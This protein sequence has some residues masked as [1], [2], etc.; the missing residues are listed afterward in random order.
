MPAI[1]AILLVAFY[2]LRTFGPYLLIYYVVAGIAL[3]WQW[4]SLAVPS[5]KTWLTGKG[6][7]QEEVDD[8]ARH[9]GFAWPVDTALG[10]LALHTAAAAL[11]GIHFGSWL[12]S[13]WYAWIL[14]LNGMTSHIP[15]GD[16]YLHHFE[17]ASIIPAFVVGY[18]LSRYLGRMAAY[19]WVLPTLVLVYKLVTFTDLQA[20]VLALHSSMRWSYFFVIQRVTPTFTPDFGGVDPI[21]VAQQMTV[22]APFCAG[23]AS[24]AG[25]IA[26]RYDLLKKIF[27]NSRMQNEPETIA[28]EE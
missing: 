9:F 16:D 4:Y 5:W 1:V 17:L 10:P 13:R 7:Q 15:S 19:A 2:G 25:A 18:F 28:T 27:G 8:L 24:S 26:A 22:V 23:L 6:A 12:V 11:C 21:R 14:P 3:A 20:S